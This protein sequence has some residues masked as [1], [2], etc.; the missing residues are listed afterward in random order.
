[1]VPTYRTEGEREAY[2]AALEERAKDGAQF[3]TGLVIDHNESPESGLAKFN[4]ETG[5]IQLNGWHPFIITF[6]EEFMNKTARQP[7][8]LLAMAE[9]LAEA[10][11]HSIGVRPEQIGEFLTARDQ[12]LRTLANESGRQSPMAVA[13]SLQESSKQS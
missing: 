10:H 9:I 13:R 8:E 7:L 2:L 5:V 11:L 1:M 12:L 3:V 6:H 4:T